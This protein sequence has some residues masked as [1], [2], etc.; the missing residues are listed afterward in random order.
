M[1]VRDTLTDGGR[2]QSREEPS[3]QRGGDGGKEETGLLLPFQGGYLLFLFL[4]V[5]K[6]MISLTEL[7]GCYS[8]CSEGGSS[9]LQRS[10]SHCGGFSGCRAR[11]LRSGLSGCGPLAWLL[12]GRWDLPGPGIEPVSPAVASGLFTT[13]PPGKPRYSLSDCYG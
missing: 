6:T 8:G 11:A 4:P 10:A 5:F 9:W 7:R 1:W 2:C 13:E 3:S 12:C